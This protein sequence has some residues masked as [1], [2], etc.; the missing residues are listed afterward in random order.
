MKIRILFIGNSHTYMHDLPAK[1]QALSAKDGYECEAVMLAHPNWYLHQHAEEPEARFNI[2]YGRYDYVVLQE[3]AHPFD[4]I[5][6]YKEAARTLAGQIREAGATS[7]IF[8][9]W[10]KKDDEEAQEAMNK[11][12][13]ELAEEIKALYAPVGEHWWTYMR[14]HPELELYEED[15]AHASESGAGFAAGIIWETIR[16]HYAGN[17]KEEHE[18]KHEG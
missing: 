15:G 10:A 9:T 6:E 1:V 18:G 3:H 7:V 5:E 4:R 14:E 16:A 11:V 8:G 17:M 13:R 12:H 2:K